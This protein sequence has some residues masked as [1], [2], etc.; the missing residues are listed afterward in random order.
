MTVTFETTTLIAAPPAVVFDLSLDIDTHV[1]SQASASERA[2]GGV[3]T[4][5]IGLG[6]DVTWRAT[7]FH[8]PFTMTS[9]ITEL[10]R[11]RRFVDEQTRGPFRRFHHEHEFQ[12]SELGTTMIDRISFDAPL[13][14]LGRL[15]ER[16]ALGAY[17]ERLIV[18]R[19]QFLKAAAERQPSEVEPPTT[20]R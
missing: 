5:L 1:D 13:G 3:T 15:V 2:I 17:L 18:E 14:P 11:P 19:G 16:L 7:H 6:E 9:R 10:D 4:G 8:V 12:P 20:R